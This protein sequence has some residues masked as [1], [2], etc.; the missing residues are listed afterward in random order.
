ME[1]ILNKYIVLKEKTHDYY[2]HSLIEYDRSFKTKKE[3][4]FYIQHTSGTFYL[5]KLI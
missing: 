4:K 1:Q 2:G 5:T 3:A